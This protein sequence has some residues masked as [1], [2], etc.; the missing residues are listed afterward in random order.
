MKK[1]ILLFLG[2]TFALS[3]MAQ[4]TTT[5]SHSESGKQVPSVKLKDM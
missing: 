1:V 4:E 2:F 5:E 3:S